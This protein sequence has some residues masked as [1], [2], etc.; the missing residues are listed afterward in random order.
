MSNN[1][2]TPTEEKETNTST[3]PEKSEKLVLAIDGSICTESELEDV[4]FAIE[5]A[6]EKAKEEAEARAK[7]AK[8]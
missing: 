2:S 7:K 8:K 5:E 4:N 6:R 3:K 1:N